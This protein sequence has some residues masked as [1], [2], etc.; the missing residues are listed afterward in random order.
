MTL[1]MII[2]A[3][4]LTETQWPVLQQALGAALRLNSQAQPPLLAAPATPASLV[5][6]EIFE[7]EPTWEDAE[8]Q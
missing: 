6:L 3:P 7:G 4:R 2:E 8:W 5:A 1:A